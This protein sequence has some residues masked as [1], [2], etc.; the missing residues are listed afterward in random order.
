MLKFYCYII[1]TEWTFYYFVIFECMTTT[2][3]DSSTVQSIFFLDLL[4]SWT[5][6]MK[7]MHKTLASATLFSKLNTESEHI[8]K[9]NITKNCHSTLIFLCFHQYFCQPWWHHGLTNDLAQLYQ[10]PNLSSRSVLGILLCFC[11]FCFAEILCMSFT[12]L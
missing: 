12:I 6:N 3:K 8:N 5:L 7:H 1:L 2:I 9:V 11:T 10:R 4:S